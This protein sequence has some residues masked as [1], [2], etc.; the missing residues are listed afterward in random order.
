MAHRV[1]L[2]AE[3]IA[4]CDYG[5]LIFIDHTIEELARRRMC[6]A[7]MI[8][9]GIPL[10]PGDVAGLWIPG[11]NGPESYGQLTITEEDL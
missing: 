7:Q 8:R 2:E 4:C 10:K 3:S 11:P 9:D 1:T 6:I 5:V